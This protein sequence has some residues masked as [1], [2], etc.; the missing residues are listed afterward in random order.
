M[1]ALVGS[2]RLVFVGSAWK[3]FRSEQK[4]NT[5]DVEKQ[6]EFVLPNG[7]KYYELRV[8][9]GA[10]PRSGDLVV[11]D[12]KGKIEGSGEVLVD[13]FDGG[14]KPLALVRGLRPYS[15]GMCEGLE[16][17]LRSM[18]AGGKRRVIIPPNLGFGENGADLG[19]GVQ[20]LPSATLEYIVDV[21]KVSI[22]P[23]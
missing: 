20:I 14:K 13:T 1:T 21:D 7:I 19:S 4:A 3:G 18:Q 5:R 17:V 6:E 22:V 9:G 15:K 10:S 23:E 16:Y 12:L 2:L 11:I 8:G